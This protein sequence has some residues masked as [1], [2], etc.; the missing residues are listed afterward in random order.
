M[1][2]NHTAHRVSFIVVKAIAAFAL[3]PCSAAAQAV[4]R[5]APILA[6]ADSMPVEGA[7]AVVLFRSRPTGRNIVVLNAKSA[8]AMHVG[9]S[10]ALLDRLER[11]HRGDSFS[12]VI[13]ISDA[14]PTRA[15]SASDLAAW[16]RHLATLRTRPVARLGDIG[17][18]R[19]LELAPRVQ[20]DNK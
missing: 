10:L 5:S 15:K 20:V 3:L 1:K 12:A 6:V 17:R 14:I 7:K 11:E 4:I 2:S 8:A 9:A 19:W 18:G 13:P 16:D